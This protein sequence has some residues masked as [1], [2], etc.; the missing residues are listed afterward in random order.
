MLVRCVLDN[1]YAVMMLYTVAGR[2]YVLD[3]LP[4]GQLL[5]IRGL[6]LE[7]LNR[8]RDALRLYV[9]DMKDVDLAEAYCDR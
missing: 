6:M 8:H 9:H 2:R 7:R 1:A 3:K 5:E 4:Q